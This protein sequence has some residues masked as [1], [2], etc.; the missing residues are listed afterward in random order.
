MIF[1]LGVRVKKSIAWGFHLV[2]LVP[3]N[4]IHKEN[5]DKSFGDT[6][7]SLDLK[8]LY[9]TPQSQVGHSQIFDFEI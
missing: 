2:R 3:R 4:Y 8:A 1:S 9:G 6:V 7:F 5:Q